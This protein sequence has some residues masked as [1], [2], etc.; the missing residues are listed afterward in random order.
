MGDLSRLSP[1]VG[2]TLAGRAQAE[3]TLAGT[4]T[5]P[6]MAATLKASSVKVDDSSRR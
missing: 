6:T 2:R 1:L 3:G 5:D 4:A